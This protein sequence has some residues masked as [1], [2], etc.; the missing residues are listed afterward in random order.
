MCSVVCV[1]L[2]GGVVVDC[3]LRF[4]HVL[5]SRERPQRTERSAWETHVARGK[6][7]FFYKTPRAYIR[8]TLW[9][10]PQRTAHDA[11]DS[12]SLKDFL[13]LSLTRTKCGVRTLGTLYKI[14][15]CE[16][17]SQSIHVYTLYVHVY[18]DI[19]AL[20]GIFNI[21]VI[22]FKFSS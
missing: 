17:Y 6:S 21:P 8:T 4:P 14:L 7:F 2:L 18:S 1:N 11:G 20:R 12:N 5:Q 16:N 19:S 9:Y 13:P 3:R 22:I 15:N 10:I